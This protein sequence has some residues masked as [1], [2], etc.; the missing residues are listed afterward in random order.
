MLTPKK[1]YNEADDIAELYREL[2]IELLKSIAKRLKTK[3]DETLTEW[4][5]RVLRE[6]YSLNNEAIQLVDLL[7]GASDERIEEYIAKNVETIVEETD[8]ALEVTNDSK[9]VIPAVISAIK[10]QANGDLNNFI[11]ETL[12]SYGSAN[13]QVAQQYMKTIQRTTL[14]FNAGGI[15]LDEAIKRNVKELADKGITSGFIDRGGHHWSIERYSE[16]VLRSIMQETY[17]TARTER[18]KELGRYTVLVSSH[19]KSREACARCQG[20]VVDIRPIAEATDGYPSIYEFGYGEPAGHRGINCSHMWFPFVPEL[21]KNHQ[22]QYDPEEVIKA[23]Q[24][25]QGR[26]YIARKIR[27]TKKELA[28]ME[29]LGVDVSDVKKKLRQQQAQM[30][31]YCDKH[32]LKRNRRLEKNY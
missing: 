20:K 5:T 10:K 25:E 12:I 6:V 28:T 17:N 2:E 29:A 24:V 4:Q 27:R 9:Q 16:T 11:R 8:K 19:P 31:E 1:M 23:E 18:M 7:I 30:R 13:G 3:H 15:T 14:L 26:K 32:D 22:P 21:H